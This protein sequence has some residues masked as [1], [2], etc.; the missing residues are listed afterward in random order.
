MLSLSNWASVIALRLWQTHRKK[1]Q[2][3]TRSVKT[4]WQ[5]ET[6]VRTVLDRT[7]TLNPV[8]QQQRLEWSYTKTETGWNGRFGGEMEPFLADEMNLFLK[9][10]LKHLPRNVA[11]TSYIPIADSQRSQSRHLAAD[12]FVIIIYAIKRREKHSHSPKK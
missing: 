4:T 1:K 3:E 8:K 5:S 6:W 11:K 7:N 9:C 12:W 2:N 10:F